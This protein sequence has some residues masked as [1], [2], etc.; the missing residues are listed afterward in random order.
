MTKQELENSLKLSQTLL[1]QTLM[2]MDRLHDRRDELLAQNDTLASQLARSAKYLQKLLMSQNAPGNKSGGGAFARSRRLDM[3]RLDEYVCT[4]EHVGG[5]RVHDLSSQFVRN[6][7][8]IVV[9][10]ACVRVC[11]CVLLLICPHRDSSLMQFA[12]QGQAL[13]VIQTAVRGYFARCRFQQLLK[14]V[15]WVEWLRHSRDIEAYL[16]AHA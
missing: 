14:R 3:I 6:S 11:V 13:R 10:S 15:R 5:T 7:Q 16:R 4:R 8:A 12:R 9:A 1:R 2:E